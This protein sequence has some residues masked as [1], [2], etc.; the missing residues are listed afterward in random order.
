MISIPKGTR[1]PEVKDQSR[2]LSRHEQLHQEAHRRGWSRRQF[3]Q[4]G[5]VLASTAGASLLPAAVMAAPPGSGFPSQLPYGSPV[6]KSL[7]GLDIPFFLPPEVDPFTDGTAD[8]TT[9][10]NFNGFSGLVE[11]EG[12]SDAEHNS[13]GVPR[14]W[15]SDVRFMKG[16][17]VDRSGK[18]QRGAFGFF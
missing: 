14:T 18:K 4:M 12:V 15:A 9:I 7:F 5:A 6:L 10:S 17:F 13:D 11:A 2:P 8:P 1:L 3:L 16:V